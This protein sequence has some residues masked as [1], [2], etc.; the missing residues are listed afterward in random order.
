M[1]INES[2]LIFDILLTNRKN[3]AITIMIIADNDE[4]NIE[5]PVSLNNLE[6]LVSLKLCKTLSV[7]DKTGM[8]NPKRKGVRHI[9]KSIIC[10]FDFLNFP[11]KTSEFLE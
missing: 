11:L 8:I 4:T 6:K 2:D 10:L 1:F 7:I 3:K 5:F 9:K